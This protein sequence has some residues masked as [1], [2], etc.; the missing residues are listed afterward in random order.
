MDDLEL[1]REKISALTKEIL[2]L[3]EE[4][5][6]VS[7]DVASYKKKHHMPIFQPEREKALVTNLCQKRQ[8]K[9]ACEQLLQTMMDL[10]KALQQE[11]I[12]K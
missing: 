12:E 2:D 7:K 3:F 5:L 8:Y 11:E 1:Y 10:S 9:E 4:R 6:D